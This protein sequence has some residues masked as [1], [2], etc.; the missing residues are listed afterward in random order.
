MTGA[1]ADGR[2]RALH[3]KEPPEDSPPDPF[4]ILI[5]E[6]TRLRR[7][8]MRTLAAA[9]FEERRSEATP[10]FEALS[11]SL[12]LHQKR[13]ELI[14]YPLCERLFGGREG[15]AG[16]LRSD[17]G[18]ILAELD[19]VRRG[20]DLRTGMPPVGLERIRIALESHFGKEERVLFPLIAAHL[21]GRESALLARRLAA[22]EKA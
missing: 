18:S 10:A 9:R 5:E 22:V 12:R 15:A 1:A 13:E 19:T 17:H 20:G 4:R 8:L 11:D 14:L 3:R 21:S 2:T 16:V 6:H 7:E